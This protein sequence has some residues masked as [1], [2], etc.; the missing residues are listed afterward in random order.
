MHVQSTLKAFV[1]T[2]LALSALTSTALARPLRQ[3]IGITMSP[4]TSV[5]IASNGAETVQF[6]A[7]PQSVDYVTGLQVMYSKSDCLSYCTGDSIPSDAD[8]ADINGAI[9]LSG[10]IFMPD[11]PAGVSVSRT[12]FFTVTASGRVNKGWPTGIIPIVPEEPAGPDQIVQNTAYFTLVVYGNGPQLPTLTPVPP[13][14]TPVPPTVTP[15]PPTLTPVPPASATPVPP[16][17]TPRPPAS[18][19]PSIGGPTATSRPAGPSSTPP[20]I[21][22]AATTAPSAVVPSAT[23]SAS[24]TINLSVLTR[25][26]FLPINARV[27]GPEREPNNEQSAAQ[28]IGM[29]VEIT[30][31]HNDLYDV[32]SFTLPVTTTVH[33][34]LATSLDPQRA[35]VAFIRAQSGVAALRDERSDTVNAVSELPPGVNFVYIYTDPQ[36]ISTQASYRLKLQR[37]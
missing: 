3:S 33:A 4:I 28:S 7:Y 15:V 1:V 25:R 10:Q 19:T 18:S 35:Q 23:P 31:A 12:Y 32:Y 24:P 2:M 16:S 22:P 27:S 5:T 13:T 6:I 14:A 20:P 26:F 8:L 36:H 29:P 37:R 21:P 11:L 17:S 9:M 34:E 30:G